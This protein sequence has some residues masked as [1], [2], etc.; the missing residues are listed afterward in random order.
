MEILSR[1]RKV[2]SATSHLPSLWT[3]REKNVLVR[4]HFTNNTI[5]FVAS[6]KRLITNYDCP[7]I[8]NYTLCNNFSILLLFQSPILTSHHC[9]IMNPIINK[10]HGIA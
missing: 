10:A 5:T 8:L 4:N 6:A 7:F 9:L 2:A 1:S 3:N